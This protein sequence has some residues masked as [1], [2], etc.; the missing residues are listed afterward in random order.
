MYDRWW[1]E[2]PLLGSM[3]RGLVKKRRAGA[4]FDGGSLNQASL[5]IHLNGDNA[6]AGEVSTSCLIRVVGCRHRQCLITALPCW[7][8][9]WAF[10]VRPRLGRTANSEKCRDNS[11]ADKHEV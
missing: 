5:V 8:R 1:S 4:H 11:K 3:K 10:C 2:T 7:P 6:T 9:K